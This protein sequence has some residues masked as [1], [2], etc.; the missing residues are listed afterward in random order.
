MSRFNTTTAKTVTRSPVTSEAVP[1]GLTHEGAPGYARDAKGELFLLAVAYM[2]SDATFYE[3]GKQRDTRF[4]DLVRK[5]TAAD[6]AWMDG[7][8]PWLRNDANMRTA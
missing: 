6:P 4:A 5:V 1:S 7:F 8:I 3:T 2:G